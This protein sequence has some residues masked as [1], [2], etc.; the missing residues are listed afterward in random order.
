MQNKIN[1]TTVQTSS[2]FLYVTLLDPCIIEKWFQQFEKP[3]EV[4]L[5]VSVNYMEKETSDIFT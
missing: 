5:L 3:Y 2:C 4:K 1:Y